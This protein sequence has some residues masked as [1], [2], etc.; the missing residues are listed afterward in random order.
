MT[1]FENDV[2]AGQD[3]PDPKLSCPQPLFSNGIDEVSSC[4]WQ[5]WPWLEH[6]NGREH[7]EGEYF[8]LAALSFT[9]V[10]ALEALPP[11]LVKE[12]KLDYRK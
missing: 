4:D 6:I 8:F 10:L 3:L 9:V 7:I 12:V 2:F 5:I 1:P 11:D